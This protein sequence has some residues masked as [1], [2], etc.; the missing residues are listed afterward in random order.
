M[1]KIFKGLLILISTIVFFVS[2]LFFV[3]ICNISY[4][5]SVDNIAKGVSRMDAL[6]AMNEFEKSKEAGMLLTEVLDNAYIVAEYY[7]VSS[8]V[9]DKM[10][11]DRQVK[12]FFGQA[13]GNVS[14]YIVNGKT[15]NKV[16]S[17]QFNQILDDNI[18]DWIKES[19]V[20]VSYKQKKDFLETV[21]KQ[22]GKIIDNFS[23]NIIT[24]KLGINNL[25]MLQKIFSIQTKIKLL[26]ALIT[27]GVL[28]VCLKRKNYENIV[29]I[30]YMSLIVGII[31][32]GLALLSGDLITIVLSKLGILLDV[33]LFSNMLTNQFIITGIIFVITSICLYLLHLILR[34]NKMEEAI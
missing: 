30:G 25:T 29:Y 14:D 22:S 3:V 24:E 20:S 6:K 16:S 32:I 26:F 1:T 17:L 19:N 13:V 23:P 34:K 31:T 15:N 12:N 2:L 8:K 10:V 11:M 18:D 28:I 21:K 5:F 4:F 9:I 27:S 7:G 33:S